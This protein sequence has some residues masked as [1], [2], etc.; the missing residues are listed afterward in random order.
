[1]DAVRGD[2]LFDHNT[3][4]CM[5]AHCI[6]EMQ[7]ERCNT[8]DAIQEMQYKRYNTRDAI[9]EMQYKRYNTRD[10]IMILATKLYLLYAMK[11][12]GYQMKDPGKKKTIMPR[13]VV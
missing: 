3:M 5:M 8:R 2:A 9:Q 4:H 1:V 10:T 7:Y 6:Q 12:L 11:D 13:I